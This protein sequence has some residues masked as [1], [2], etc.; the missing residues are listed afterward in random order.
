VQPHKR[1]RHQIVSDNGT[2]HHKKNQ[3]KGKKGRPIINGW[4]PILFK[5]LFRLLFR[6]TTRARTHLKND[7]KRPKKQNKS[8]Y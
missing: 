4:R 5:P 1:G 6:A 2:S 3:K 7:I 8:D